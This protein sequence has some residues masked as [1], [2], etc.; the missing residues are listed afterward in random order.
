MSEV[1]ESTAT[2]TSAEMSPEMMEETSSDVAENYEVQEDGSAEGERGEL[3]PEE[4]VKVQEEQRKSLG[5][6]K[7]PLKV[8]GRDLEYEIDLDDEGQ[9]KNALQKALAADEKFQEASHIRKQMSG[10]LQ[11]L[12]EN[13]L[14]VLSHPEVGVNVK[15]LAERVI[16]EEIENMQKS[17]EQRRI[18]ELE[19]QLRMTEEQKKAEEDARRT[20]E[21]ARLEE[22]AFMQLDKEIE[23]T[24]T[25][26][27]VP[28]SA[29]MVKRIADALYE[30]VEMGYTDVRVKDV[31]P[32]VQSQMEREL[33]EMFGRLPEEA[34]ERL[35]GT[36]L[37]RVRK[38]K[39]A[40]ARKAVPTPNQMRESAAAAA[41]KKGN[42]EP[43]KPKTRIKDLLRGW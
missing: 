22:E 15:E 5:K 41:P 29:Y 30:A 38:K 31:L 18:E 20:A 16:N 37:D 13:P 4:A 28:R 14:A 10:L 6:R 23:E 25:S 19:R 32:F 24:L 11:A 42:T 8:N 12:K 2:E 26:A 27:E 7:V 21:R 40:A 34:I 33:Q 43:E 36:N 9:L 3:L 17:P 35:M 39:V 1:L